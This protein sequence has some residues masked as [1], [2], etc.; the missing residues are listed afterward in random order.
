MTD[1]RLVR[2]PYKKESRSAK[3]QKG[4][5][6]RNP[7]L[8]E[9]IPIVFHPSDPDWL[10]GFG[11]TPGKPPG[12]ALQFTKK[13]SGK[14]QDIIEVGVYGGH[15]VKREEGRRNHRRAVRGSLPG[16]RQSGSE[17]AIAARRAIDRR[18]AGRAEQTARQRQADR[19]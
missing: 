11:W 16:I 17:A 6:R 3:R 4:T 19:H 7:H 10:L 5:L 1:S 13:A 18:A 2:V 9:P 8:K 14:G 12:K 15:D